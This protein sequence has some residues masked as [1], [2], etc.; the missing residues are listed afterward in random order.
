MAPIYADLAAVALGV[1]LAFLIVFAILFWSYRRR[2]AE[3][4]TIRRSCSK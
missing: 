2:E 1:S 3:P 4:C